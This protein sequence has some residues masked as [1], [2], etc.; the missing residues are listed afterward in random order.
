MASL[1]RILIRYNEKK[2]E[3]FSKD[4]RKRRRTKKPKMINRLRCDGSC[5]STEDDKR[6]LLFSN[7]NNKYS[8]GIR[9]WL[10]MDRSYLIV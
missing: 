10:K 8:N 3:I 9:A 6:I 1:S 2:N 5:V 7:S 4:S